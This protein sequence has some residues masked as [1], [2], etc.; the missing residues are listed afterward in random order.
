MGCTKTNF[1]RAKIMFGDEQYMCLKIYLK[2][3]HEWKVYLLSCH[4]TGVK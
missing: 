1:K 2:H 3:V 4:L